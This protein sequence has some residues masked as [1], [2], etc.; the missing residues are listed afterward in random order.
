[1]KRSVVL[2]VTVAALLASCSMVRQYSVYIRVSNASSATAFSVSTHGADFDNVAPGS[3]TDYREI[4]F[5]YKSIG[6]VAV[7]TEQG[8]ATP[9]SVSESIATTA[10]HS[11][12]FTISDDGLGGFTA[13]V[14]DDG[15]L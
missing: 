2:A 13:S 7:A 14:A 12:T 10:N 5:G 6:T 11:Y 9:R 4:E 1:M 15:E 8:S 3:A